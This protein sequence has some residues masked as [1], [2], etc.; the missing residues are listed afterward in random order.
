MAVGGRERF[1]NFAWRLSLSLLIF[2]RYQLG[3]SDTGYGFITFSDT[4]VYVILLLSV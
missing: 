2:R 4:T 1:F 3:K